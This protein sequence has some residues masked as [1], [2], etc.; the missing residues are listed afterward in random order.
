MDEKE[1]NDKEKNKMKYEEQENSN[2]NRKSFRRL[3]ACAQMRYSYDT[4][5]FIKKIALEKE[6]QR[7]STN[8]SRSLQ[9]K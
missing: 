6:E 7:K 1:K 9:Q 5:Q 8:I 4:E 2:V 3:F